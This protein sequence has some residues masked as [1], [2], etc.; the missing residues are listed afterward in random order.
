MCWF[1]PARAILRAAAEYPPLREGAE[2]GFDAYRLAPA[3]FPDV[4]EPP[5]GLLASFTAPGKLPLAPPLCRRV[6]PFL[7][8]KLKTLP[9]LR[10]QRKNL[11][12]YGLEA[13]M[14]AAVTP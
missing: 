13:A 10:H 2:E 11:V 1:A 14:G 5:A 3:Q 4:G 7:R 12:G 6:D 9:G 8:L